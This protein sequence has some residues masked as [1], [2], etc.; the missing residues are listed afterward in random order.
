M[1]RSATYDF[2]LVI[3]SNRRSISH[4]SREK[5]RF[6]S[7]IKKKIPTRVYNAPPEGSPLSFVMALA[8]KRERENMNKLCHALIRWW[9]SLMTCIRLD[10]IPE[11]MWRTDR[12]TDLP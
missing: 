4:R 2:L 8:T 1:D 9:K 7:K 5:Q 12:R 11:C 6:L 3:H 10:T